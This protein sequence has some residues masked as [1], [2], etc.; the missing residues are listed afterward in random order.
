M[1]EETIEV[2]DQ[3]APLELDTETL[4]SLFARSSYQLRESRKALLARHGVDDEAALLELIRR[5]SVAPHPAYE[6]YLSA[7]LL[8]QTRQQIRAELAAHLEQRDAPAPVSLHLLLKEQLETHYRARLAEP[9]RLA[10][11]A[12]TLSF[13]GGL[14]LE[15][16]YVSRDEYA[17]KWCWGACERR[18]DTAPLAD[19]TPHAGG[20]CWT[21]FSGLLELL[22]EDPL[23]AAFW[24]SAI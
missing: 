22:L 24:G 5:Q 16:R 2:L 9:V 6:D 8:E 20:D 15:V 13:D 14:M 3:T 17:I 1:H 7:R 18:I 23:R 19:W 11:D 12:L 4:Q 21:H 10:P